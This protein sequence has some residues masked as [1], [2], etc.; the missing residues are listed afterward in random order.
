MSIIKVNASSSDNLAVGTNE[1]SSLL[2]SHNLQHTS[3]INKIPSD[4]TVKRNTVLYARKDNSISSAHIVIAKG[5]NSY[6]NGAMISNVDLY[7]GKNILDDTMSNVVPVN[8]NYEVAMFTTSGY[9]SS[10]YLPNDGMSNANKL[11]GDTQ[12]WRDKEDT[13]KVYNVLE[14]YI[15]IDTNKALYC[16]DGV[17]I[18]DV[19]TTTSTIGFDSKDLPKKKSQSV[20][21][22]LLHSAFEANRFIYEL[23][24]KTYHCELQTHEY[25]SPN[26]N[27]QYN[28][29]FNNSRYTNDSTISSYRPK[30]T[31]LQNMNRRNF[32]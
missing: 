31:K 24:I 32:N 9:G 19:R 23:P 20:S 1:N 10:I 13:P 25:L 8:T 14:K 26:S 7:L 4:T 30:V 5:A 17:S 12:I 21:Q 27:V 3:I 18:K 15:V 29:V 22:D 16:V 2:Y 28:I 6:T 11:L